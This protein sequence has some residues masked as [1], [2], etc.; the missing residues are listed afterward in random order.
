MPESY[1]LL[2]FLRCTFST[3]QFTFTKKKKTINKSK[4]QQHKQISIEFLKSKFSVSTF[5][6]QGK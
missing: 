5:T 1:N 6:P 2:L 3:D 4:H